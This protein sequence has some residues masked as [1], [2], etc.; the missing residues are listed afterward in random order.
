MVLLTGG[1][2]F[3]GREVIRQLT[4]AGHRVRLVARR[5][6]RAAALAEQYD[7]EVVAGD[8]LD[9]ASLQRAM[10][11]VDAVVHLVGI[12]HETPRVSF[13]S[14]H[15][16]ATANVLAAARAAG[17]RRYVH[18]SALGTRPGAVS[19]YHRSKWEAEE[20]VRQSG[21]DWTI[22]RP[23]LVYGP[24]DR[25]LNVLAAFMRA[26]LDFWNCYSFPN[27]GG[28]TAQVQPVAVEEVALAFVRALSNAA[29]LGRTYDLCGP[30]PITWR[31][32][33][34]Q[35]AQRQGARVVLDDSGKWFV[36]RSL[37]WTALMG[38]PVLGVIL[39]GFD[40]LPLAGLVIALAV[41][42]GLLQLA[43]AWRTL[44]LYTVPWRYPRAAAWLAQRVLPRWLHF[45]EQLSMLAEDNV[46]DPLPAQRELHLTFRSI[47][48]R[49]RCP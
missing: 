29:A 17:V 24:G 34:L 32:L 45:G 31:E 37:L 33:L 48:E 13:E 30:A 36:L 47:T 41:T 6:E 49:W 2:G 4:Q 26:P 11:G 18:M 40:V 16:Q 5:P 25:S 39:Y 27:L 1:T 7:C 44:L 38:V 42:A 21:L 22:L 28:G 8:V 23:S 3:I 14:A 19:R 12:I 43:R 20:L 46:G 9:P 15:T 35:L 10:V